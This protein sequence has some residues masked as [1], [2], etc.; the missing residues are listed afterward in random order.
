[1][2][3]NSHFRSRLRLHTYGRISTY[4]PIVILPSM[5]SA[6]FHHVNVSMDILIQK[7]PCPLCVQMRASAIQVGF[8]AVYPTLLAPLAGFMM[9]SHYNTYRLPHLTEDPKAVFGVWKKMV[10]PLGSTLYSI[11]IAQALIAMWVT[12]CEAKSYYRVQEVL[13]MDSEFIENS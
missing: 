9:A 5:L 8:S 1:M 13:N 4:L 10:K 2:Y 11:A 6:L 7:T 3:I 12:Y